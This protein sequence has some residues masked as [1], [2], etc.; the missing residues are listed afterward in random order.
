MSKQVKRPIPARALITGIRA[1]GYSFSTAVAD[2]IDNSIT[3]DAKDVFVESDPLAEIPYFCILDNGKGMDNDGL[4]NALLLGSDRTDKKDSEKELGRF[5]LGLKSASLSQCRKVTVATKQRSSQRIFAMRLDLDVIE[6]DNEYKLEILNPAEILAL[7][8]V[9]KLDAF[10]SGTL[11]VWNDFDRIEKK[12]FE[13]NFRQ[14][15]A[16]AKKHVE[17]VFHNFYNS[18]KIYF[19][20]LRI[21]K[22]DPFLRSARGRQ[23][24]KTN[25]VSYNGKKI[26]ITAHT[27]PYANSLFI[28]LDIFLFK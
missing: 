1:I 19:N 21:E 15:V 22:R 17:L 23:P 2:I 12:N 28:L 6:K 20:S 18:I 10:K 25:I 27:L 11:V 13:K 3:A 5:G 8:C 4:D 14:L 9:D 16:D 24:G 7:P 26:E